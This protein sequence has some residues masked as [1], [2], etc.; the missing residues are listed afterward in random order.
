MTLAVEAQVDAVPDP[1][2]LPAIAQQLDVHDQLPE[3]ESSKQGAAQSD[4]DFFQ[5]LTERRP[6]DFVQKG[7]ETFSSSPTPDWL[8]ERLGRSGK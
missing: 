3:A 8:R 2:L 6:Y 4:R 5:S 1:S 7:L